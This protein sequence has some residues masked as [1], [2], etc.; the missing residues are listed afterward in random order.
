MFM[1]ERGG[2]FAVLLCVAGSSF[3]ADAPG[4]GTATTEADI[5]A[6]NIEIAPSGA[7]LPPGRGTAAEGEKIFADKCQ[8]CH[9]EKGAGKPN[10]QLVGG[11]GTLAT[12]L[13]PAVKTVGSFWPHATTLFDYTRRAMPWDA[14]R[15]LS[16]AEV[17][18]VTA[19]IL[20]ENKIIGDGDVMDAASLP[21]VAMPNRDGFIPFPRAPK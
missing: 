14:P 6:W 11:F 10:D 8:R 5:A 4:L 2:L 12:P 15:T 9:G 13:K 21:K 1:F 19:Y 20:R 7:G 18:A 16:D 17:Y 3:A